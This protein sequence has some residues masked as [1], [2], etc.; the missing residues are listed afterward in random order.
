MI[1][2]ETCYFNHQSK[3]EEF[4]DSDFN[5]LIMVK[6]KVNNE[7]HVYYLDN[8][9][10]TVKYEKLDFSVKNYSVI[11]NTKKLLTVTESNVLTL[12]VDEI[13]ELNQGILKKVIM[14]DNVL[15]VYYYQDNYS[16][17]AVYEDVDGKPF[18]SVGKFLTLPLEYVVRP[19]SKVADY[20][21]A[22]VPS[23]QHAIV[24]SEY[25]LHKKHL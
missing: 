20:N 22:D 10:Q 8:N 6:L 2:L 5:D 7:Y 18:V 4:Y 1:I 16:S 13:Y 15:K 21:G 17:M 11:S 25:L 24:F 9:L 19:D 3:I 14:D 12:V 23:Y